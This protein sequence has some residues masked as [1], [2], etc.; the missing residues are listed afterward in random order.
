[1]GRPKEFDCEVVLERALAVFWAKGYEATSIQDLVEATGVQRQSLYDTYGDKH[2]LYLAALRRY[3]SQ[4]SRQVE[5]LTQP[6]GSP[7]GVLRDFMLATAKD[8][9]CDGIGCMVI[10]AAVELVA[11]DTAVGAVVRESV[12]EA[13]R[14]FAALI[15]H[16]RA[17]GEVDRRVEVKP[18]ARALVTL[19]WGLRTIG[20][21]Q[22][23]PSWLQGVVKH[24][25]SGLLPSP[26]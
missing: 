21:T 8:A 7:L 14:A 24:A 3:A 13:E 22:R 2:A 18:V 4:A 17:A 25:I 6:A 5:K 19:L 23:D 11:S 10:S 20:R 1:V 15:E 9:G 16:A 12:D 26:T